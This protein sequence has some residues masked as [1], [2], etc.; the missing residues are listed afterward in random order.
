MA[1]LFGGLSVCRALHPWAGVAFVLFSIERF[2]EWLHDMR[3]GPSDADWFRQR[4]SKETRAGIDDSQV[5]KY[6][7]GQKLYFWSVSLGA[8][9]LLFSGLVMWFPRTFPPVVRQLSF[10][11]HD[12]TFICFA[13][14]LVI[15]I[16][17]S[18]ANEPGTFGSMSR[19]TVT[20]A[21]ARLHHPRWYREVMSGEAVPPDLA[22][23]RPGRSPPNSNAARRG[24]GSWPAKRRQASEPLRFA[25]GLYAAQA[26]AAEAIEDLHARGPLCGTLARDVACLVDPAS[27]DLPVRV[28]S[29]AA[30]ARRGGGVPERRTAGDGFGAAAGFLG[31]GSNRG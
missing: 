26:R 19:G 27:R 13:V 3:F 6:N 5:G 25:A 17:L 4:R 12:F 8:F 9:G 21:W 29:G 23:R 22:R 30:P 7:G 15:H 31:G 14:S 28:R 10:L 18:T 24:R 2:F 1:H 16:Y 11:L 20:R